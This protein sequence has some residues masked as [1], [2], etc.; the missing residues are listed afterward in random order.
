LMAEM[1]LNKNINYGEL[2][3]KINQAKELI[4]D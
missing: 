2:Y 4:A 3:N 1:P